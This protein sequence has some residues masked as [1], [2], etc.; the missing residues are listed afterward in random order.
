MR[1]V[2]ICILA[3]SREFS[4]RRPVSIFGQSNSILI[5]YFLNLKSKFKAATH[6]SHALHVTLDASGLLRCSAAPL[7]CLQCRARS[8]I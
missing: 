6:G 8:V 2:Y 5:F 3:V 4:K 1:V 7:L